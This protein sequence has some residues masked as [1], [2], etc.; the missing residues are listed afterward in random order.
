MIVVVLPAYNEAEAIGP[1]LKRITR[2]VS[3]RRLPISVV[4]V[5]DG[6][7]DGTPDR[8]R[9]HTEIDIRV[10]THPSNR[11]LGEAIKTGLVTAL[12]I[13][14]EDD[15]VVTMDADDSHSPGLIPRMVDRLEEGCD[16]VIASRYLPESRVVGLS[17]HREFMS[18]AASWLFRVVCPIRGVRD[19][20][21]GYR[22]YR[23]AV[24]REA[25]QRWGNR[26]IDQPGFSCEVDV[27]LKLSL[28]RLVF[29]EVPL[30][31][32]YDRKPGASKMN[33]RKTIAHTLRLLLRRRRTRRILAS[34]AA[35]RARAIAG[36]T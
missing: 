28:M 14:R 13:A 15:I 12:E 34:A 20:T 22:A 33:V 6:S 25:F 10:V 19:Y 8:A 32:R 17:S 5:D 11:G 29:A 18:R 30:V 23:A 1:L 21:C 27:L 31:L 4:L 26:F 24:L 36:D 7:T 35:H 2:I 3:Q 9:L 16:V